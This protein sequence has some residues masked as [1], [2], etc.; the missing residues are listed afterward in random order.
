M[1]KIYLGK[2]VST[3]GIKGEIKILSDFIFKE[4]AFKIGTY[5]YIDDKKYEIKTYRQ[6]K[7]FD[8]ITLDNYKDINE[9]LFLMKKKV[10]KDKS[11]LNL[12]NDEIL[13]EDLLTFKV[14]DKN[15]NSGIIK[16]IFSASKNNKIIRVEFNKE[17]LI[18][19]S[20]PM[21]KKI[22]KNKK[23]IEVELIDGMI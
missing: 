16:E 5:I 2:I 21:I 15:K 10:Y 20:S 14:I 23:E 4:K 8:M 3:H 12:S 17:V 18:P 13:D 6:H 11:E 9:I 19:L 22:D 1:N 7:N